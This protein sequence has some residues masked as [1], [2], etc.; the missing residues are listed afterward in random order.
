MTPNSDVLPTQTLEAC[1]TAAS[2]CGY[3]VFL[4]IV[5]LFLCPET[6]HTKDSTFETKCHHY[7]IPAE[8]A[9]L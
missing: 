1:G 6:V 7:L 3:L 5:T 4:F 8:Q 2:Y 9:P